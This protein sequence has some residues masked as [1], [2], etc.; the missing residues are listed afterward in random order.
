M[1]P[2]EIEEIL[3]M[4]GK[5]IATITTPAMKATLEA[6]FYSSVVQIGAGIVFLVLTIFMIRAI[7]KCRWQADANQDK[8][9][10]YTVCTTIYV[11]IGGISFIGTLMCLA[12]RAAWIGLFSPSGKLAWVILSKLTGQ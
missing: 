11:S 3:D 12:D 9:T 5:K 10:Y 7:I 1:K 4:V 2:K 6:M 8:W